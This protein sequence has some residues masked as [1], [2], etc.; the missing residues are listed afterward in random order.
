MFYFAK[1]DITFSSVGA[2]F[3]GRRNIEKEH[4]IRLLETRPPRVT[5]EYT[6]IEDKSESM[7]GLKKKLLSDLE[8]CLLPRRTGIALKK[9]K[10]IILCH[11]SKKSAHWEKT[12][13]E[14]YP[15]HNIKLEIFGVDSFSTYIQNHP[16]L[17]D[18]FLDIPYQRMN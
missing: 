1:K 15:E 17:A 5:I 8:K 16:D 9:I 4:L 13:L 12:F 10:K 2:R 18:W 14:K 3:W 6:T 11:N 7:D